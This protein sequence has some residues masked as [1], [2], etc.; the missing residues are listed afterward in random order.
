VIQLFKIAKCVEKYDNA[1]FCITMSTFVENVNLHW[2]SYE[3]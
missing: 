2:I 3:P 1:T